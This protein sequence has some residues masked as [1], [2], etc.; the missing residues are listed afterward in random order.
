[1]RGGLTAGGLRAALAATALLRAL[2]DLAASDAWTAAPAVVV[3]AITASLAAT[4][5]ARQAASLDPVIA[6]RAE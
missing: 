5:P 3:L 4:I 1:V 6:L 2:P